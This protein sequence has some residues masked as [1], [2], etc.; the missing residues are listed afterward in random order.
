M[1]A[2]HPTAS[3]GHPSGPGDF[4]EPEH[5]DPEHSGL[6]TNER[7]EDA[8]GPESRALTLQQDPSLIHRFARR[9]VASGARVALR[10]RREGAWAQLTW[11]ECHER[12]R[13]VAAGWIALGV[14]PG[15]R[16]AILASTRPEWVIADLASWMV[17]AVTVPIYLP[18]TAEQVAFVLAD[19]AARVVVCE[20]AAQL[21]KVSARRAALPALLRAICIDVE[22][23]SPAPSGALDAVALRD[24][25][26]EPHSVPVLDARPW[27]ISW[28]ELEAQGSAHASEHKVSIDAR[29]AALGPDTLATIAYTSG[30]S[31]D[32]KGV[33]ISH[34]NLMYTTQVSVGPLGLTPADTQ[35][36]FLPLAHIVG[37]QL[38]VSTFLSGCVTVLDPDPQN[39]LANCQE[40]G[41]SYFCAVPRV[42]E[43]L[44]TAFEAAPAARIRAAFGGRLRFILSGGASLPPAVTAFFRGIDVPVYEGYGL[45]ETTGTLTINLPGQYRDGSVGRP[46]PGSELRIASDGEILARGPG[47]MHGYHR[48]EDD[49]RPED[50]G[51]ALRWLD[52][53]AWLCTGDVG[54]IDADGYLWITDRK[55]DLF[56]LSTGKYIA[57]KA[58]ENRLQ[59]SS[60]LLSQAVI[61]GENRSYVTALL[62]LNAGALVALAGELQTA[63]AGELCAH[64]EVRRRIDEAVQRVNQQLAPFEQVRRFALVH[65]DFGVEAGDLTPSLKLRRQMV[66]ARH[67]A[68]L[69]AMYAASA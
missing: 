64:A 14:Q 19:S 34:H 7:V 45:T 62:T 68:L 53:A 37:R 25:P 9:V 66:T 27:A 50:D 18:S 57:P 31:G 55:K 3:S 65:P 26:G 48:P 47:M 2:T 58:I 63:S 41:V 30:T 35:L 39:L 28:S 59:A 23:G 44:Y 22:P 10:Y 15:D 49:A 1:N 13:Q 11:L 69:D 33:R 42:L 36:L 32:P 24:E 21:A 6:Y 12:A 29:T 38:V 60:S 16:I 43:K 40:L 52:G 67:R 17:G 54:H 20:N 51:E 61:Y 8:A 4:A 5:S 46:V 56:K